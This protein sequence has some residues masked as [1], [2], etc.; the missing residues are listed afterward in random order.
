MNLGFLVPAFLFGALTVAVPIVL[1]LMRRER[2][3]RE[4]FSDVRFLQ[5]ATLQQTRRQRLRDLLLLALRVV[6]LIL[7]VLAFARPFLET[8]PVA[9]Q[10]VTVVLLD[11]SFSLSAPGQIQALRTAALEELDETPLSHLVGVVAFDDEAR[12]LTELGTSRALARAAITGLVPRAHRTQYPVGLAAA[13]T[14]IGDR[15]GRIIVVTD[16]QESGWAEGT[17]GLAAQIAVEVR[18][19]DPPRSNVAVVD[20]QADSNGAEAVL[21]RVGTL[22]GETEVSLAVEGQPVVERRVTLGSGRSIVRFPGPL[23]SSGV[24]TVS[25]S[26]GVGY[27][28]DNARYYLLDSPPPISVLVITGGTEGDMQYLG[29]ALRVGDDAPPFAVETVPAAELAARVTPL[30]RAQSVLLV[31]TRGLEG[32]GRESLAAAVRRGAGLLMVAGPSFE[33]RGLT[34]LFGESPVVSFGETLSHSQPASLTVQD[35]RHPIMQAFSTLAAGLS[36]VRFTRTVSVADDEGDV[37]ATFDDGRPAL[38]EYRIGRGQVLVL[39]SDLGGQWN[40][41]HRRPVFI[42]FLHEVVRHLALDRAASHELFVGQGPTGTADIPGVI[43]SG[44]ERFVLNVDTRESDPAPMS[45]EAFDATL[46]RLT[47]VD[48]A[49]VREG[50]GERARTQDLWR[51]LLMAM[52]LVLVAEGIVGRGSNAVAG[53]GSQ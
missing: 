25:A 32:R 16:R 41:L 29:P 6:A 26:D 17:G 5:G 21:L 22:A 2:L 31:G 27:A 15:T 46:D 53:L 14:L 43:E 35:L 28:A 23:P 11:T 24:V 40:D 33:P 20:I 38:V 4:P 44:G 9:D 50:D 36:R 34:G 18:A 47:E 13:S 42:P 48:V 39:G 19:V 7:L 8:T 49:P 45:P 10:P 12:V 51:Y 37:V 1:H 3:P 30:E 52:I